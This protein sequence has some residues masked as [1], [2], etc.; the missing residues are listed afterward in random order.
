MLYTFF[1][2]SPLEQFQIIPLINLRFASFLDFSITNAVVI[3]VIVVIVTI[4]FGTLLLTRNS[5]K[6]IPG[7]W[8][9]FVEVLHLATLSIV[10]SNISDEK[11]E[12][13]FP[14][15]WTVFCVILSLN[16]I[17]LFPYSFTL[18]G[19]LITTLTI[20]LSMFFGINVLCVKKHKL[21]FFAL[22]LPPGTSFIL[23][24]LLVPIELISYIFKPISLA[25]RLFANMMAG[26]T[27]LK[28]IAGFA[29]SLMGASGVLF[30]F[31]Y[32]PLLILVVLFVLELAVAV[33]QAYVFTV[34]I[35]IYLNDALNLH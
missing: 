25:V 16:L 30:F 29:F 9:A 11:A 24:L 6:I 13:F 20:G 33:I 22:F 17:G 31:H 18:T 28:V 23:S 8:Q 26:H 14:L 12:E 32:V 2:L 15:I 7:Y 10:T 35:C 4:L 1:N 3:A 34:L 21:H 19:H 27:L 5:Y